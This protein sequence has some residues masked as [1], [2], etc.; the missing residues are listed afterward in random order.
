M[1]VDNAAEDSPSFQL[2]DVLVSPLQKN[3]PGA[4]SVSWQLSLVYLTARIK[5]CFQNGIDEADEGNVAKQEHMSAHHL[6]P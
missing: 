2:P 4:V 1:S 5:T 6:T 3:T